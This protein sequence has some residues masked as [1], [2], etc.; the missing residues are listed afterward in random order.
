MQALDVPAMFDK[1][2]RQPVQR[3]HTRDVQIYRPPSAPRT[4]SGLRPLPQDRA[5]VDVVI[6]ADFG[7]FVRKH[8][9]GPV[10]AIS[11][12][13]GRRE[14]G[15]RPGTR[16]ASLSAHHWHPCHL[17]SRQI[18]PRPNP[19]VCWARKLIPALV[20]QSGFAAEDRLELHHKNR[21]PSPAAFGG[22]R[23]PYLTKITKGTRMRLFIR[24]SLKTA[25]ASL[26]F[27]S[28]PQ[29]AQTAAPASSGETAPAAITQDTAEAIL[30][31][32]K[33]IRRV[34][35]NIERQG[36]P[37]AVRGQ[38]RPQTAKV[39]LKEQR[40]VLGADD[41]PV[42]VVEFADYQ[43]PFCQ[44]FSQNVFPRLEKEYIDTGKVRW[45]VLNMPLAFHKDAREAAQAALCAGDQGRFWEMRELLF[46]NPKKLA[47]EYLAGYAGDLSL[48]VEAFEA[49]LDSERHL[50]EI[51]EDARDA[52]RVGLTG[53]PSFVVGKSAGDAVSGKVIVGARPHGAF[54]QAIE[55]ALE[56]RP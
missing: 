10:R 7:A 48:D 47:A 1:V 38:A 25:L 29:N 39:A 11:S 14:T 49:C 3:T 15:D 35:E 42:T 53:T 2:Q 19:C 24:A 55:E 22:I 51:D 23:R 43:C 6:L 34:L 31:E 16:G 8:H 20:P 12:Q 41:A 44:R 27:L 36:Q 26:L 9:S 4:P 17:R 50:A 32:L 13:A 5:F 21:V 33:Q 45:V 46:A 28:M 56:E 18:T 37:R 30:Q 54:Q 40:P 52:S